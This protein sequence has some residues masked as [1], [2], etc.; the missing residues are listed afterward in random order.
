MSYSV[1]TAFN[2]EG[3]ENQLNRAELSKAI[4]KHLRN[5]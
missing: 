3:L 2:T 5:T 1:V 4:E